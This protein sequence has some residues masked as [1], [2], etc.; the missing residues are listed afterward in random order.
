MKVSP[1]KLK[2]NQKVRKEHQTDYQ[3]EV[4]HSDKTWSVRRYGLETLEEA[5]QY[6]EKYNNN[7]L[8]PERMRIVERE[9]NATLTI[10]E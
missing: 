4:Q 8:F 2:K 7:Y 6:L 10:I 5:R 9:W 1:S 3:I